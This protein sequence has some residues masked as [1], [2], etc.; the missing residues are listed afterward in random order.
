MNLRTLIS[1][2]IIWKIFH[3][4][5]NI[6][7]YIRALEV[8]APTYNFIAPLSVLK[9][10]F[11]KIVGLNFLFLQ[12]AHEMEYRTGSLSI[13]LTINTIGFYSLTYRVDIGLISIIVQQNMKTTLNRLYK[14]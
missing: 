11:I 12:F 13:K 2:F 7:L 4:I 3:S 9:D 8:K 10:L 14:F 1:F 5:I 6:L